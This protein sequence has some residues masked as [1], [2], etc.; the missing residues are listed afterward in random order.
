MHYELIFEELFLWY[1]SWHVKIK[2][3]GN[4]VGTR[5]DLHVFKFEYKFKTITYI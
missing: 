1:L 3:K 2:K 4:F 5:S